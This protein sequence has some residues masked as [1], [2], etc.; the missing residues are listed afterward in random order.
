MKRNSAVTLKELER[1][2]EH[3]RKKI[4]IYETLQ[5]EKEIA[6]KKVQGPFKSGKELI[7]NIKS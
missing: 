1:D 6:L 2:A 3:L 7:K 4:F 5:A